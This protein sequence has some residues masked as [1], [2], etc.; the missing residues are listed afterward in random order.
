MRSKLILYTIL[1]IIFSLV[2]A[3]PALGAQSNALINATELNKLLDRDDVVIID[4]RNA[5]AYQTGHIPG[6]VSVQT[7][8]F[9]EDRDGVKKLAAGPEKFSAL[10]SR[11]GVNKNSR[12]I[13]YSTGNDLKHATRLWWVFHMYGHE[14]AQVLDGGIDAW[15]ALGYELSTQ[16]VTPSPAEYTLTAADV[17]QDTVATTEEVKAALNTGTVIVDCRNTD[18]FQGK[19]AKAARA[20]HIAGAILIS[21]KENLNDDMTFKNA[22]QLA[23]VYAARG[24]TA[25]T[26]VITYCNTGTTSTVHYFALTQILGYKNVQNYDAAL[27]G[28]ALDPTLPMESNYD[29]FTIGSTTANVN[30][31]QSDLPAAPFIANNYSFIPADILAE[32]LGIDLA[33]SGENINLRSG[34]VTVELMTGNNTL[35]INGTPRQMKVTP[36][37]KNGCIFLPARY[38]AEAF[39]ATLEWDNEKKEVSVFL[40]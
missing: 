33:V 20:G 25:G 14:N 30:G 26:P 15:N 19:A 39:G 6:A 1:V 32:S 2:L 31:T 8:E 18:Y 35:R 24:I 7:S 22:E 34:D 3:L 38:V 40:P 4:V 10:L 11:I 16:A 9:Y 12:V 21:A 23:K 29:F 13:I 17:R 5:E 37:I 28:W 36:V 27:M